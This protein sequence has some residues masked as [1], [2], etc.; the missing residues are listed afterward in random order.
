MTNVLCEREPSSESG[1]Y[2]I[3]L[4]DGRE[5]HIMSFESMT[6]C[7]V[8]SQNVNQFKA[9]IVKWVSTYPDDLSKC[10][11]DDGDYEKYYKDL[12][13]DIRNIK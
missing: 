8:D 12:L 6:E 7:T 10:D 3:R 13:F 1:C 5:C 4:N 11:P 9:E 2:N